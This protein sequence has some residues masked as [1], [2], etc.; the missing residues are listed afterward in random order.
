[1]KRIAATA[2]T[3][4]L[5]A[6]AATASAATPTPAAPSLAPSSIAV[7]L[8]GRPI[9]AS[10]ISH[11]YCHDRDYPVIHCHS[12]PSKLEVAVR[13]SG[14]ASSTPSSTPESAIQTA[15]TSEYVVIYSG[16]SYAGA[17]MYLFQDYDMLAFIGWNDRI[18]SYR[19]P[20]GTSEV[21]YT[22]WFASGSSLSFCCGGAATYL[23]STF[24]H[25]I[26][27]TYR[28]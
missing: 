27:S 22:D 18:R 13:T 2:A 8:D 7:E 4:L 16:T 1:M 26:S 21:F 5:V 23:P 17:Y 20:N 11:H 15:S 25:Q 9:P 6:R 3:L 12:T 24:D 28:R 10:D 19:S 14:T